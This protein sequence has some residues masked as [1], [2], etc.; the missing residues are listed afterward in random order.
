MSTVKAIKAK[1]KKIEMPLTFICMGQSFFIAS[2]L[3]SKE[4]FAHA[5]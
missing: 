2:I 4:A 5:T 1:K 3:G